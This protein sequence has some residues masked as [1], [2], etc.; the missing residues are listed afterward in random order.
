MV[1]DNETVRLEMNVTGLKGTFFSEEW[2]CVKRNV[3]E[4]LS[5]GLKRSECLKKRRNVC[6]GRNEMT[7]TSGS[8]TLPLD[9]ELGSAPDLG[10]RLIAMLGAYLGS[11]SIVQ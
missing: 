2:S 5:S 4:E 10:S 1:N 8:Y 9:H 3:C 6:L 7:E 11:K